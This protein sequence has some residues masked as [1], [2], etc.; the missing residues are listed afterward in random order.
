MDALLLVLRRLAARTASF[1]ATLGALESTPQATGHRLRVALGEDA[2]ALERLAVALRQALAVYGFEATHEAPSVLLGRAAEDPSSLPLPRI[3][4]LVPVDAFHWQCLDARTGELLRDGT[5][6]FDRTPPSAQ[7][8][9]EDRERSAL[10][11]EL[12]RRLA[13]RPRPPR[14]R[15]S[16][17]KPSARVPTSPI[18]SD[19]EP[20]GDDATEE[21]DDESD[22]TTE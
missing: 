2:G 18:L 19:P 12:S 22:T 9:T 11:A 10:E 13:R 20:D 14:P 7:A 6:E 17:S 5:I 8:A 4:P 3:R 1:T 15:T 16:L 21:D